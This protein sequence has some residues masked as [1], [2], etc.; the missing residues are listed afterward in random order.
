MDLD[1]LIEF[2]NV[3]LE[4][5]REVGPERQCLPIHLSSELTMLSRHD[6]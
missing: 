5:G 3:V 2:R 1:V 6:C 4:E